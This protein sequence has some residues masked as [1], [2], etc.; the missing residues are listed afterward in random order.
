ME[1]IALPISCTVYV[2]KAQPAIKA[3]SCTYSITVII[4]ILSILDKLICNIKPNQSRHT[5]ISQETIG[6]ILSITQDGL[7]HK[8]TTRINLEGCSGVAKLHRMPSFV[9]KIHFLSLFLFPVFYQT[10]SPRQPLLSGEG[11]Q[12]IEVREG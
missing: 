11:H 8:G 6:N 10:L 3:N 5:T 7:N 1:W 2:I 9:S 4:R 12:S